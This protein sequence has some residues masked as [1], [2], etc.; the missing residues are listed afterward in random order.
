MAWRERQ[1]GKG[2]CGMAGKPT[3][4]PTEQEAKE[5]FIARK[6]SQISILKAQL[7]DAEKALK[8]AE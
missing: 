1:D 2:Y 6:K 5:S 7:F 8:L 3:G 4:W